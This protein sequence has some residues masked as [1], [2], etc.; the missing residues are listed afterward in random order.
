MQEAVSGV[1]EEG[2][3]KIRGPRHWR[4]RSRLI[5]I[6]SVC[7]VA[8]TALG[9]APS[10]PIG[11]SYHVFADTRTMWGIPNALDVLSN[12]PFFFVGLWG[13]LWLMGRAGRAGFLDCRERI[14]Y[15]VFFTGVMFTGV[16]SF[17]Y[18]LSPC[19]QRLPWDL[20]PMTCAFVALV[21]ATYMERVNVR[22]GYAALAPLLLAGTCTV[23]YW[24]F[25]NVTGHG[26]YKY[27]LF[28]PFFSP[29]VLALLI[30]LFPPRYTGFR[31]LAIAFL[32][33]VLAKLFED[34]DFPIY[35]DLHGTV[36]GHTLKHLIAGV[37]CFW[38]LLMLQRRQP[39]VRGRT[40][41]QRAANFIHHDERTANT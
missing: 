40:G 31:F 30:A 39:V 8:I 13:L 7:V 34:Y 2:N 19:N 5:W 21:V 4:R 28:F 17:W 24:Y 27:Y 20:V 18:H 37:A 9:L 38:V 29:V 26:D 25:G 33:Y 23:F 14:P 1:N 3:F 22:T 12:L 10:M 35:R 32:F 11:P 36:S 41:S 6:A 15:L 16:G